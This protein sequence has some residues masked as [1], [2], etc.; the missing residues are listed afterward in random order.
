[1]A[2]YGKVLAAG[3]GLILLATLLL[4]CHGR[5]EFLSNYNCNAPT[6]P[7]PIPVSNSFPAQL[8]TV[9]CQGQ[10]LSWAASGQTFTVH[11]QTADCFSAQDYNNGNPTTTQARN[12]GLGNIFWCKYTITVGNSAPVDPHVI[13]I[14]G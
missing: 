8:V 1:M 11:F 2:A 4:S 5:H 7:D 6:T 9:V 3:T 10:Q 14:G 13:V 12:P